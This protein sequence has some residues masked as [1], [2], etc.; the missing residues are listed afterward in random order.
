MNKD[1][2][3]YE[4]LYQ[5]TRDGRVISCKKNFIVNDPKSNRTYVKNLKE[6]LLKTQ[7]RNKYEIVYLYANKKGSTHKVHRL[8]AQAF[9][10]NPENK[11]QVNHLNG[12]KD[13]NRL[14]N[15]EWCTASENAKHAFANGLTKQLK[16]EMAGA[17]K[18]KNGQV[19]KIRELRKSTSTPK[20]AKMFNVGITTI[21]NICSDRSWKHLLSNEG[22]A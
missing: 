6:N 21:A 10:P 19:L 3:G 1:I 18:L 15:L 22:A 20:L 13:D 17:S 7:R 8:V 5:I 11:P 16:G 4:G 2:K 12:I 14:E 9:I